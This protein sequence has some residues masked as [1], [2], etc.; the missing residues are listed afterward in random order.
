[1][2]QEGF[3]VNESSKQNAPFVS[4]MFNPY[5]ELQIRTLKL[6]CTDKIEKGNE[7]LNCC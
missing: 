1:M 2:D 4:F 7:F 6:T 5:R 3:K